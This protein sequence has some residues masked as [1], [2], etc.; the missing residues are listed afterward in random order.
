[1]FYNSLQQK[2]FFFNQNYLNTYIEQDTFVIQTTEKSTVYCIVYTV[3][4]IH[5][6]S[7][8]ICS[9]ILSCMLSLVVRDNVVVVVS[10]NHGWNRTHIHYIYPVFSLFFT[11]NIYI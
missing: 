9:K 1:M 4:S 3:Y 5:R 11:N 6:V 2:A 7:K 10:L 8:N